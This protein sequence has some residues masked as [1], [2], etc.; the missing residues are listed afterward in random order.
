[1]DLGL[2]DKAAIVTG[3]SAGIG[4]AAARRIAEEGGHVAVVARR[5]DVLET[6]A[7]DIRRIARGRVLPIPADVADP[8]AP[9]QVVA[10]ALEAFGRIDIL[11]NNA[12]TS[13]A[14]PFDAV[15]ED[16]WKADLDL[17][18]WS[19]IRF[20]AAVVPEM[21]KVGGGRIINVTNLAGR[22]PH[23]ASMP[24]AVS[25]AAGIALTKGLS[26]DLAKDN[27]LVSTVCIGF[28]KSAQHERRYAAKLA[29][30]P[31]TSMDQLYAEEARTRGIPLGRVG[32]A[33]EAGDVI[34][35]LASARSSYLTGIAINI[36]GGTS[37]VV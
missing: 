22:T 6:A 30:D 32:E 13:M 18:L 37:M 31:A 21:R 16:E 35:F 24:T 14:K 11:V 33:P 36:D 5:A 27:I 29:A 25:R 4:K 3:G 20:I 10:A 26:K 28:I 34:A 9:A 2:T 12:G 17:K 8:G 1:M 7:D 23:A 15:T 19:A